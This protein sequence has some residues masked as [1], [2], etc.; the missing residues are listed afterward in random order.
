[1][2]IFYVFKRPEVSDRDDADTEVW[3]TDAMR[4]EAPVCPVCKEPLG[5]LRLLPPIYMTLELL[6][7]YFGDV[8]FVGG[9]SQLLFSARLQQHF[10]RHQFVGLSDFVPVTISDVRSKKRKLKGECPIYYLSSVSWGHVTVD[11]KSSEF[12][13]E[14]GPECPE[15][16]RGNL[17]K[18]W[19]RIVIEPGTWTGEDIFRPRNLPGTILVTA[20]FRDMYQDYGFRNGVFLPA[21][22]YS[23]DFYPWEKEKIP[24][25]HN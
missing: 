2:S 22:E 3:H 25:S 21:S 7:H 8:V 4:G 19:S 9:S 12:E 14:T 17:I 24:V 11:T 20:R 13:W 16:R 1:M 6:G 23:H 5:S 18:R 15:C 10:V